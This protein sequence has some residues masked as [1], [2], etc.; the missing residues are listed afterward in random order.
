LD[1]DGLSSRLTRWCRRS[2]SKCFF[3]GPRLFIHAA[4]TP[5]KGLL[6]MGKEDTVLEVLIPVY[7]ARL[8]ESATKKFK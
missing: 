3:Y 1:S 8:K 2:D 6:I 5:G 4:S 7:T